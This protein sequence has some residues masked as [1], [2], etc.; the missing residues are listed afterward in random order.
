M[1]RPLLG[2]RLR[3]RY[4]LPLLAMC[5]AALALAVPGSSAA[6]ADSPEATA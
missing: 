1:S 2:K 4:R 6:P 3:P 5:V